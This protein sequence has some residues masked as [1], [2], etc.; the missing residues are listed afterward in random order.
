MSITRIFS[1]MN[2]IPLV[3]QIIALILLFMASIGKSAIF[4]GKLQT[5][6]LGMFF[7]LA[8]LMVTLGIHEAH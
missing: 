8:S 6:P 7:W 3:L 4:S 5:F 2:L 1:L